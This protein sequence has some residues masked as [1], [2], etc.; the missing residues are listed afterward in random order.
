M[1]WFDQVRQFVNDQ[2]IQFSRGCRDQPPI[3]GQVAQAGAIS[4][5][6]AL[7]HNVNAAGL[8]PHL[9]AL[10]ATRVQFALPGHRAALTIP[11]RSESGPFDR[12]AAANP[13]A[14]PVRVDE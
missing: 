13:A 4:P 12:K 11:G 3:D 10:S 7:S 1:G 2:A 8:H 9:D 14:D 6:G 5:L